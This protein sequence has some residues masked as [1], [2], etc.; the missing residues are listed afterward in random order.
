MRVEY[1]KNVKRLL[2]TYLEEGKWEEIDYII[3]SPD[4]LRWLKEQ[5]PPEDLSIVIGEWEWGLDYVY[6]W[7]DIIHYKGV[8]IEVKR[9]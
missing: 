5:A 9:C 8:R 4:E 1:K 3:L 6:Q 7:P 2:D